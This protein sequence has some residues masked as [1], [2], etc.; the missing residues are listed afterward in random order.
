MLTKMCRI[1]GVEKP[2]TEFYKHNHTK[3]GYRNECKE[4]HSKKGKEHYKRE[5]SKERHRVSAR[6]YTLKQYGLDEASYKA[7]Y[8]KQH[9]KC[10][11]CGRHFE[12]VSTNRTKTACVDHDHKTGVVRGLLCW[13][14]NVAI[15]K[16]GDNPD[17]VLN[18]YKYLKGELK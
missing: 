18:A 16:L 12:E 4:C 1:C 3:D 7:L 6:K 11:I 8:E 9:G 2:I 10:L 14:C 15:G 5:G 17:A 13:N